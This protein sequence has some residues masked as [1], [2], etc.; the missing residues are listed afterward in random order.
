MTGYV[1]HHVIIRFMILHIA[2]DLDYKAFIIY[3]AV[4]NISSNSDI[5]LSTT[6]QIAYLKANKVFIKVISKYTNFADL[7]PQS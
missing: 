3:I 2:F 4:F 1:I 6:D 5:Y 7:F